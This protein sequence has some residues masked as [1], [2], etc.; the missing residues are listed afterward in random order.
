MIELRGPSNEVFLLDEGRLDD[1]AWFA[2]IYGQCHGL[3]LALHNRTGWSLVAIVDD[4]GACGHVCVRRPDGAIIDVTGAHTSEEMTSAC[5]GQ[6]RDIDTHYIH[7][8][9]S[10]HGWAQAEPDSA[11]AWVD[12]VIARAESPTR[13][14]AMA[15]PGLQVTTQIDGDLELKIEWPGAM[16][17]NVYVRRIPSAV[18]R[19]TLYGEVGLRPDANGVYFIDYTLARLHRIGTAWL[20]SNFDRAKADDKLAAVSPTDQAS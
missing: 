12:A 4:T 20:N 5:A 8:L 3:A 11:A 13:I 1:R 17:L 18:E 9:E 10:Q 6:I 19:W 15:K 7:D 16:H 14:S 2:F